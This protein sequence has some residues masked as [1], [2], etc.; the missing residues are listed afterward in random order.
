VYRQSCPPSS[1]RDNLRSTRQAERSSTFSQRLPE[2]TAASCGRRQVGREGAMRVV[3]FQS[4]SERLRTRAL[5][6][7]V[8]PRDRTS[9]MRTKARTGGIHIRRLV[10]ALWI[11]ATFTTATAH[12]QTSE[13]VTYYHADAIGSIRMITDANGQ[14]VERHDYLPFGEEWQPSPS[15]ERRL[16]GGKE[17]DPET[18]FDYFGG[19]YYASTAGRFTTVDP[20]HVNADIYDP[21]SWNAYAYARSN[22]LRFIDPFGFGECP[23]STDT[24]TCVEGDRWTTGQFAIDYLRFLAV[25]LGC[26]YWNWRTSAPAVMGVSPFAPPVFGEEALLER[27]V[28][29]ANPVPRTL[30]RVVPGGM[31]PTMLA[32]PGA[33]DVFVTA[34][35]DIAG[36]DAA[37]LAVRLGIPPSPSF[38]VIEFETPSVG[39]ASPVFRS[40]PGFRG[41]GLTSGGAREFVIPNG[42]IPPGSTLR[43]VR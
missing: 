18:A 37:Q 3:G 15:S 2:H 21:Q 24:S 17:R 36:L 41:G 8:T 4:V 14:V 43:T 30:A 13:V 1:I 29:V 5:Y 26:D 40:N 42:P 25:A 35:E 32:R 7:P 27:V 33:P 38:T 20:G 23:A 22:P 11:A 10:L 28:A 9:A 39:I 6:W 12:A 19:R 34:A 31:V 16:Y